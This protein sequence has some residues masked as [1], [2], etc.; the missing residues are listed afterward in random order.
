MILATVGTTKFPFDRLLQQADD[1]MAKNGRKG[2]LLIAQ[3]G[4][5][6]YQFRYPRVKVF[7][8]LPFDK[9]VSYLKKLGC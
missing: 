9:F 2:E 6:H 5:S 4:P 8:E 7:P 3:V 1:F